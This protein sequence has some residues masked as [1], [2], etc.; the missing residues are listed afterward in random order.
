MDLRTQKVYDSLIEAFRQLLEEKRFEEITV[1]ELCIRANTR[2]AT[3]Y[4]HFSDK[5]DFFQFLLSRM[6]DELLEETRRQADLD[7]PKEYLHTLV[8]MGLLFVEK[9]KR[10]LLALQDS[11]VAGEMLQTITSRTFGEQR[12][13][14]LLE[15]ELAVQFLIG[16]L[17]QCVRWW[18]RNM[19]KV[20][21]A[22]VQSRL[23]ELVDKYAE[24]AQS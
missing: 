2:R 9:N 12:E 10:L 24:A 7:N 15:D 5:Y 11:D 14:Y 3:F 13:H 17:N 6:R 21:K 18:L 19:N 4:K 22:D 1:N 23:Y 20:P 8:D 16:G